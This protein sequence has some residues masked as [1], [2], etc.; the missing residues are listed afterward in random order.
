M[1]KLPSR[2][3]DL[4]DRVYAMRGDEVEAAWEIAAR[5]RSQ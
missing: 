4:Y 3:G 2:I 5:G 1:I